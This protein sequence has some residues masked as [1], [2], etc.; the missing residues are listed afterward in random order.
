MEFPRIEIQS[1]LPKIVALAG[2]WMDDQAV[3]LMDE[4]HR[5][6]RRLRKLKKTLV[7]EDIEVMLRDNGMFLDVC[8]LFLGKGQ[9]SVAHLLSEKLNIRGAAWSA[10]RRLAT[11]DPGRMAA[12]LVE[13]GIPNVAAEQLN[14]K[15]AIED[16][17][18]DRYKM[19]RGRAIAGQK[20]GR[21]LE[22][23]LEKA[24]KGIDVPY[25]GRVTFVG[26]RGSTAKCDFAI[27]TRN[28][29]KIVIEAKG[30]EATG[31]KLTDFLGDVLKIGQAKKYHMY[32]F[33]VTDGRGW[34][35]R[36]S[37]LQRLIDF[38]NEGLVDMIYTR[39]ELP[40]LA[41]DVRQIVEN[42]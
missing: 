27:P 35:N 14:Q 32:F 10:L 6:I 5:S 11:K 1:F 8:R 33:V 31:S 30:F 41:S 12:A 26:L 3:A 29:P 20:R 39:S 22:D 42:E 36:H 21:G 19:S 9:E 13:I 37:D 17:L 34:H 16:V 2:D 23:D 40:R 7:A 4:V 15:W 25:E 18:I 28:D 24:L 38:Q